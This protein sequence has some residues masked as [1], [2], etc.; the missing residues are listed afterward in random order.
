MLCDSNHETDNKR[1]GPRLR[2]SGS[3]VV[4]MTSKV[5]GTMEIL[6]PCRSETPKNIKTRIGQNDY[7]MGPLTLPFFVQIVPR[8]SAP[9]IA[10]I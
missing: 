4:N 9:H 2:G 3:T 6:T 5:N 10:E 8:W 1:R 7:V